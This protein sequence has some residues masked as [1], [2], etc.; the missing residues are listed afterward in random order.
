MRRFQIAFVCVLVLVALPLT[1]LSASGS[2]GP[3]QDGSCPGN[4]YLDSVFNAS[5][6]EGV[7]VRQSIDAK[8][9]SIDDLICVLDLNENAP[10]P[11]NLIDNL[12]QS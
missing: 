9:G 1:S 3:A 6:P 12:V 7:A 10:F 8:T 4:Y 2:E 11:R 5:T